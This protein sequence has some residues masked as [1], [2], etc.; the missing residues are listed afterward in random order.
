[1][2]GKETQFSA[3]WIDTPDAKTV[4]NH[5]KQTQEMPED[6]YNQLSDLIEYGYTVVPGVISNELADELNDEVSSVSEQ[7]KAFIAR[8]T[9]NAY[10]HPTQDVVDDATYR[11]IDFHVTRKR[12]TRPFMPRKLI[13]CFRLYSIARRMLFSVLRLYMARS[14]QCIRTVPMWWFPSLCNS[15]PRG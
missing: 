12:H 9:R 5:K 3:L 13:V 11:L 2:P 4:L 10:I 7:P 6:L 1:M 14:R 15:W 8:R